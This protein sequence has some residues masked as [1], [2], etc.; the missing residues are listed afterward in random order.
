MHILSDL[1]K[2]FCRCVKLIFCTIISLINTTRINSSVDYCERWVKTIMSITLTNSYSLLFLRNTMKL[3]F[4][5]YGL[6]GGRLI[7]HLVYFFLFSNLQILE[8]KRLFTKT[9]SFVFEAA[10][11]NRGSRPYL[12]LWRDWINKVVSDS[13]P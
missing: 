9:T 12:N 13:A 8:K 10:G 3:L 4:R 11:V 7:R 2:F 5:I 1:Q 6:I